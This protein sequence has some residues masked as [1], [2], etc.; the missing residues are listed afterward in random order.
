V[1]LNQPK[2]K[3][4]LR[5]QGF[6]QCSAKILARILS[7]STQTTTV[8]LSMNNL[9]QGLD[10]LVDGLQQSD[11]LVCLRLKNNNIDGR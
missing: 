9:G 8:D 4:V 2:N 1:I 6:G 5:D 3:L 11:R 7:N 10:Y